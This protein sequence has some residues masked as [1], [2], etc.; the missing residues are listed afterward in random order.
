MEEKVPHPATHKYFSACRPP[1]ARQP[2]LRRGCLTTMVDMGSKSS[3]TETN[4]FTA[5]FKRSVMGIEAE[6][7]FIRIHPN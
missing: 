5:A 7:G 3:W 6:T 2:G 4:V 1:S